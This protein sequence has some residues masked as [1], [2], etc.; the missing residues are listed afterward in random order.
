MIYLNGYRCS[1]DNCTKRA[2]YGYT[3]RDKKLY[4]NDHKEIDMCNVLNK[5]CYHS[6]CKIQPTYNFEWNKK[7]M[8]C[9]DH[10]DPDMIDVTKKM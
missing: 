8:Y 3:K 5:T 6:E 2:H 1:Y 7:P 10:C 4:C 9:G